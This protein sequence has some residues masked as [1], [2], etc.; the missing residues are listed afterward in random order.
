MA[1]R[2]R[3]GAAARAPLSRQAVERACVE[4]AAL[5]GRPVD[6]VIGMERDEGQSWQLRAQV[7][8]VE[9]IPHST[10]VLGC[11]A[12]TVDGDGRLLGYRRERR[13]V[14]SR[15]DDEEER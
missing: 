15:A 2:R 7:I 10:D 13:Y 12:L 14:R 4:L 9:R 6:A 3:N 8:E 11:Y 5:V 1:E